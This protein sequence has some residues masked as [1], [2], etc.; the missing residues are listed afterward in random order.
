M[1]PQ[2]TIDRF[3]PKVD[4]SGDCWEWTAAR[5]RKGY[6]M[7]CVGWASRPRDVYAHRFVWEITFGA[8][9]E[10]LYV[11]HHCD[12]RG[13]V[14]PAHLFTGTAADNTADMIRKGRWGGRR[15]EAV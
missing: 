3:W 6:G 12:N 13:C 15:R 5:T 14:N 9:P 4:K 11:C 8:I 2:S 10:G 7:F 1:Y